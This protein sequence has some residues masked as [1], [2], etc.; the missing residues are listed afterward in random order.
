MEA[1]MKKRINRL[2]KIVAWI[3]VSIM[4]FG[5]AAYAGDEDPAQENSAEAVEEAA[6]EDSTETGAELVV[7]VGFVYPKT[8]D[9]ASFGE[10]TEEWTKYVVDLANQKGITI[11]GQKAV[12][13]L[14]TADSQS[15]PK[16]AR[17]AAKQLI[18]EKN[19]DIMITSKT[20]DTTVPVS[21]ICESKGIVC[22]S[23][24]TPDEAWDVRGHKYSF[25]AGF[26]IS[27]ELD[28]FMDAWD[29]IVNNHRVGVMH[30]ADSEGS[31][32]INTIPNYI[33][34]R[35]YTAYDPG[36]YLP[37]QQNFSNIIRNLKT[38]KV[39]VLAGVMTNADFETFYAQLKEDGYLE[40]IKVITI[41][42][43]ALFRKD[44]EK[45][46]VEGLCTEI[47]WDPTFP[48]VSS[49]DGST[50]AELNE[51]FTKLTGQDHAPAAVGYDYANIE[52]LYAVLNSAGSLNSDKLIEAAENLDLDT[53]MGHVQYNDRNYSVQPLAEGQWVTDSTGEWVRVIIS[54]G[55]VEGLEPTGTLQELK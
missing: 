43:T 37:G 1:E 2:I 5:L 35:G 4:L 16:E 33:T 20:A 14:I 44:I 18:E 45:M 51:Q 55:T 15:D 28:C 34:D 41:A 53:V 30:P 27:S 48:Y 42:K 52:I 9:L 50:G 13:S 10:Y 26:D 23:V 25:H 21:E 32:M 8:G 11:D 12:I 24:D 17:K 31:T 40:N 38:Q 19:I 3:T 6:A 36:S 54:G 39:E 46:D 22:L 49:L 47:W 7:K 29:Q